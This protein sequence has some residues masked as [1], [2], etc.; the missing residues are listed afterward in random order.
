MVKHVALI[1]GC[2]ILSF[3]AT[4]IVPTSCSPIGENEQT[5]ANLAETRS[6]RQAPVV[7]SSTG[8]SASASS[9]AETKLLTSLFPLLAKYQPPP[10]FGFGGYGGSN[11]LAGVLKGL[12]PQL[13]AILNPILKTLGYTVGNLGGTLDNTL[14]GLGNKLGFLNQPLDDVGNVLEALLGSPSAGKSKGMPSAKSPILAGLP[15]FAILEN[16]AKSSSQAKSKAETI[17]TLTG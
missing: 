17:S 1:I 6:K 8:S 11:G 16:Q 4:L 13:L 15:L 7:T 12:S 5:E 10:V 9:S 14:D 2:V 3:S